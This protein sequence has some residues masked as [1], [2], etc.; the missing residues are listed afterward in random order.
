MTENEKFSSYL[1]R[2]TKV[3]D[4]LSVVGEAITDGELVRTA[5]NGFSKKW[6]TFVKGVVSRE[7]Q[8]RWER[9]WDDFDREEIR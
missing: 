5:L 2:I 3:R 7:N 9:L 4:E 8:P 6:N 1:T